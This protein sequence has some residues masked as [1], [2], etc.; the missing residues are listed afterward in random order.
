MIFPGAVS[1]D[2]PEANFSEA[3]QRAFCSPCD[4]GSLRSWLR[5]VGSRSSARQ[6][7]VGVAGFH[8]KSRRRP[9]Y[10]RLVLWWRDLVSRFVKLASASCVAKE[11]AR[12][13]VFFASN[14]NLEGRQM[15]EFS[16][17]AIVTVGRLDLWPGDVGSTVSLKL[18][19]VEHGECCAL[20]GLQRRTPLADLFWRAFVAKPPWQRQQRWISMWGPKAALAQLRNVFSSGLKLGGGQVVERPTCTHLTQKHSFIAGVH[21]PVFRCFTVSVRLM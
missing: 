6:K 14:V 20:P 5:P 13:R 10:R 21:F 3:G 2:L 4:V 16:T 9:D 12:P 17:Q 8:P 18:A 11:E 1:S 7:A 15:L 19:D